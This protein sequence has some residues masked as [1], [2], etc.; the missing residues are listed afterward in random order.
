ML[1][2]EDLDD[3]QQRSIDELYRRDVAFAIIPMGGGKSVI[4]LTAATELIRDNVVDRWLVL[5]PKRVAQTV[6]TGEV[7]NWR[8]LT[9][10][11][12]ETVVGKKPANR[13]S[14]NAA[15]VCVNFELLD[16]IPAEMFKGQRWGCIIDETTK[17]KAHNGKR[18]KAWLKLRPGFDIVWGLTGT[19]R[20]NRFLELFGQVRA[21]AGASIWGN[22]FA[23]W[24]NQYFYPTDYHGYNWEL[25]PG[26]LELLTAD[27][28]RIGFRI[29]EAE[30]PPR[31]KPRDVDIGVDPSKA[32]NEMFHE[33]GGQGLVE[34]GG[35]TITADS[36]AIAMAKQTQLAQGFIYTTDE[37]ED[38]RHTLSVDS[39]K[40]DALAELVESMNGQPLL[41][42]YN[43]QEDLRQILR[44]WPGTPYIGAGV[45]DADAGKAFEDWNAG[46]L[47]LMAMH[48]ASGGHGLNLQHGGRHCCW[49][50]LPFSNELYRQAIK[51]L[52][53]RGQPGQV[54]NY[55]LLARGT[56]DHRIAHEVLAGREISQQEFIREVRA[57]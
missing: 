12:I 41:V 9:G 35:H 34:Y 2:L 17:L 49:Y 46:R 53:R 32:A 13:W 50:A 55:R 19:P 56:H 36:A 24:R 14:S 45:S 51:R 18:F 4:G 23:R 44:R 37:D 11:P 29:D 8:H 22:S 6:W 10:T 27:L 52:D 1:D 48:P 21:I 25:R 39:V 57:A 15:I 20:P 16:K 43:F 31:E 38:E 3:Y 40:I 33:M 7:S 5:G 28:N 42:F 47:P 30:L 26:S 54:I